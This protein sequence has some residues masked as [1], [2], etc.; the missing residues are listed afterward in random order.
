MWALVAHTVVKSF[1]CGRIHHTILLGERPVFAHAIHLRDDEWQRLAESQSA[2]AFCPCTNLYLGSGLF[3][4]ARARS[5]GI[6][7]GVGTD[8]GAGDSLSMPWTEARV[9]N[10]RSLEDKLF[11]LLMLGDDRLV[12]Q[13][14]VLGNAQKRTQSLD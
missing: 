1:T 5:I 6:R 3:D 12:R 4:Y 8:V 10:A 2:V 7:V 9:Q 14:W 11:A 13:T